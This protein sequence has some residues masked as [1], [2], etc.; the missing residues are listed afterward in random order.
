M[1]TKLE[2]KRLGNVLLREIEE[3]DYL[4]YFDIGKDEET[5]KYVNW[6][7][8]KKPAEALY[9]IREIFNKRPILDELPKGYAI[10]LDNHMIG[11]ID[12]HSENKKFNSIEIGYFLKREYWG[13]GIMRKCVSYMTSL[14]FNLG[15]SKVVIGSIKDN[16][17]SIQLIESLGFHYECQVVEDLGDGILYLAK[18]YAK[19]E[20]EE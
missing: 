3:C 13:L 20:N 16:L 6:G 7:P 4:D 1:I 10:I 12:Y 5:C 2:N 18:Y 15:F 19:Y 17:R 11:M 9:A 14:A 8:F